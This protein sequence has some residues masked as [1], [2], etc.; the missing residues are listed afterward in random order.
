MTQT[1]QATSAS[2][3]T[4]VKYFDLHA[5][6]IGYLSR[7]RTVTPKKGDPFLACTVSAI[8]GSSDDVEYT[9]FDCR[10]SGKLAQD[11]VRLLTEDVKAEKKVL[12]AFKIGDFYPESFVFENGERKGETGIVIKGRLLQITFAKV[13]G[14]IVDLPQTDKP[15]ETADDQSEKVAE[16]QAA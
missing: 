14:D 5:S 12:I 13:D 16:K 3:S 4:A 2:N 7:I 1:T 6:G 8:H 15:A 11:A 10:V 9:K